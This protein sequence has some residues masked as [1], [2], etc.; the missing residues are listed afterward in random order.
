M[1]YDYQDEASGSD[2]RLIYPRIDSEDVK[3]E[4]DLRQWQ[5]LRTSQRVVE[6]RMAAQ[7][8][9][10]P[11]YMGESGSSPWGEEEVPSPAVVTRLMDWALTQ[12]TEV[13][14]LIWQ[15]LDS[16]SRRLQPTIVALREQGII[17]ERPRTDRHVSLGSL[18]LRSL[19]ATF[20]EL[21]EVVQ[22]NHSAKRPQATV[23][24]FIRRSTRT[25]MIREEQGVYHY[26]I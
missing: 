16:P 25:G 24:Q 3:Q 26:G 4:C 17:Q 2:E 10:V 20:E 9:M 5:G 21:V 11:L 19:P 7:T 18:L 6:R 1:N 14:A 23:R 13:Q 22:S 15:F 8:G 12:T